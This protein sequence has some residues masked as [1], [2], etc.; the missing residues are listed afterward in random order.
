MIFSN[1]I[2]SIFPFFYAGFSAW[3]PGP[4]TELDIDA[5]GIQNFEAPQGF[6][7][8]APGIQNFQAPQ[9]F[10]IDGPGDQNFEAPQGL[11]IDAPD[12]Q[13]LQAPQELSIDEP[14]NQGNTHVH[15]SMIEYQGS[16]N[17]IYI[18]K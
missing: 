3:E 8:D 13:G 1:F 11:T 9:G 10:V 6:D 12:N 17:D 14:E 18:I 2:P 4:P 5:P 15:C 7:I 16:N